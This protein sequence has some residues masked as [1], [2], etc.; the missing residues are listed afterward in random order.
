MKKSGGRRSGGSEREVLL[1]KLRELIRDVEPEGLRFLVGQARTLLHNAE[2][3][4]MNRELLRKGDG[5]SSHSR[6][7][8]S[9]GGQ[10]A[11]DARVDPTPGVTVEE[12]ADRSHFIVSF[13]RVRKFF[14]VDEFRS[15]VRICQSAGSGGEAAERLYRWMR[16]NRSD[17]L[18]D[19]KIRGDS[20][21]KELH[22]IIVSR[23]RAKG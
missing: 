1:K 13:G 17:V 6:S 21:L 23:Y 4:R 11:E 3:D 19:A 14:V 10:G 5:S 22:G 9:P 18:A 2:V 15:L 16:G 7:G 12:A 8:D 20:L